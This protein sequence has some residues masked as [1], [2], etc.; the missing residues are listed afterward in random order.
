MATTGYDIIVATESI[1]RAIQYL[2]SGE[3]SKDV[4][5]Q[6]LRQQLERWCQSETGI[7]V[8]EGVEMMSDKKLLSF[9]LLLKIHKQLKSHCL[10]EYKTVHLCDLLDGSCIVLPSY[11]PPSTTKSPELVARL[12][13]IRTRVENN[14]YQKM[15]GGIQAKTQAQNAENLRLDMQA[16]HRQLWVVVNFF[17][18]VIGSF[19][20]GFYAAYF[21][22]MSATG[23]TLTG[24]S[25]GMAVFLADIYFIAKT[26]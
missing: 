25:F 11:K 21:A 17:L 18:T 2:L 5:C 14:E 23:C 19:V 20:F 8:D 24:F 12:N 3:G 1:R 7:D 10:P 13:E 6:S 16:T 4:L 26:A 22:G 9:D 15:V